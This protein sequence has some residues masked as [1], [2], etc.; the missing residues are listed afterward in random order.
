MYW[1]FQCVVGALV[2]IASGCGK[3]TTPTSAAPTQ[4]AAPPPAANTT[5]NTNQQPRSSLRR[6]IDRTVAARDLK[7]LAIAYHNYLDANNKGPAKPSDLLPYVENN[8]K[9][10]D[11]V[12]DGTYV[13]YMN[14]RLQTLVNGTS[15]TILGYAWDAPADG[16]MV[17]YADG[18]VQRKTKEE[19]AAAFK[20]G[21]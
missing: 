3:K 4:Q 2:I 16:G 10:I 15:N 5:P 6:P 8:Q 7:Q 17:L 12:T 20:A 1:K 11:L 14:V 9:L 13:L 19:F 21:P 18:S